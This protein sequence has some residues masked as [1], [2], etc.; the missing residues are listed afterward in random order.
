MKKQLSDMSFEEL[1]ALFPIILK[2]HNTEYKN[3]Y[4]IEK[5]NIIDNIKIEDIIRINHIGS[6][7]VKNLVAK[8]TIDIL[9]E[10]DGC[11]NTIQLINNLKSDGWILMMHENSPIK[12]ELCK[13]YTPS[14]FAEKV[15][16]LHIRYSGNWNELYFR[17][18]LIK[19]P[20]IADE[21]GKLKLSLWKDYQYNRDGYTTAKTEFILKYSFIAKQKF[22]NKYKVK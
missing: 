21:Y 9:L 17:D 2:D 18:Y 13:G 20:N 22:L 4:E 7:A 19:Y 5:Q 15:F 14:G 6:T 16:H 10:I 1:W 12:W 3:W 11:C 8:P